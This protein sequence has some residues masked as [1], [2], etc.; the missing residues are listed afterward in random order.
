LFTDDY[1]ATAAERFYTA[2]T[3]NR[4]S[5]LSVGNVVACLACARLE[6]IRRCFGASTETNQ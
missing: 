3:R 4:P 2:K 1:V 5:S 6:A